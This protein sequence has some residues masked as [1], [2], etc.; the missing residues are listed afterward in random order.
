MDSWMNPSG[1]SRDIEI[2]RVNDFDIGL[3][4]LR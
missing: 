1:F 4:R 2:R 3:V